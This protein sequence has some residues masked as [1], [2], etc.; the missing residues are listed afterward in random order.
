MKTTA[1]K[2]YDKA[3]EA[4]IVKERVLE[5]KRLKKKE[6]SISV[7]PSILRNIN[8]QAERGKSSETLKN[9]VLCLKEI[10]LSHIRKMLEED[11]FEVVHLRRNGMYN[12]VWRCSEPS[13]DIQ[14]VEK[15]KWWQK[16][17]D[18]YR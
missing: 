8:E 3:I 4:I 18:V 11:G 5:E 7:Y 10:D 16:I 6:K 17:F 12:I 2:M 9:L 14:K 1:E 15:K 13:T